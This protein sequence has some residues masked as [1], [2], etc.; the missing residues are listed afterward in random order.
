MLRP[1][2]ACTGGGPGANRRH[3]RPTADPGGIVV[4]SVLCSFVLWWGTLR[5]LLVGRVDI[6]VAGMRYLAMLGLSSCGVYAVT[7]LAGFARTRVRR[8]APPD[9]PGRR[10][11][12]VEHERGRAAA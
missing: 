11:R 10:Q 1:R 5:A 3:D 12:H 4:A 2:H 6:T 8:S 9:P 7:A